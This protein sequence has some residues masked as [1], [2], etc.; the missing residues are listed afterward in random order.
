M[1]HNRFLP[2]AKKVASLLESLMTRLVMRLFSRYRPWSFGAIALSVTSLLLLNF[3]MQPGE[4]RSPEASAL[5]GHRAADAVR[6]SFKAEAK[7]VEK[8]RTERLGSYQLSAGG[9][10][11]AALAPANTVGRWSGVQEWPVVAIHATL[12]PNGKVFA[13][14]TALKQGDTSQ[15]A[16]E[17]LLDGNTRATVWDPASGSFSAADNT[18]GL[19]VNGQPTG[20]NVFCAGNTLLKDGRVFMA[21]GNVNTPS[22]LQGIKLTHLF[23]FQNNNWA[24]GQP[25]NFARWYP[26]VT[27]LYNGEVL[28]TGGQPTAQTDTPEIRANDGVMRTLTSANSANTGDGREYG[29]LRQTLNGKVAY[30]GPKSEMKLLN[31][32][33]NGGKGQ[34]ENLANRDGIDRD[35]GSFAT[36]LPGK[37]L[38]AGGG[39]G[40]GNITNTAVVVDFNNGG[41]TSATQAMTYSRR[42]HNLTLLADGTVL[43]TGGFGG[44]SLESRVDVNNAV[45]IP[46][47]WN[48]ATGTWKTLAPMDRPRMYHST[49]LLLPDGRVLS[50]GTGVCND[51]QTGTSPVNKGAYQR[52]GEVFSPPYLFNSA[53]Q[54]AARPQITAAPTN[55]NYNASYTISSPQAGSIRKLALVRF[56]GVTH[57]INMDQIYVPVNFT[58]TSSNTLRFTSPTTGRLAPHGYYMLFAINDQGVPSVASTLSLKS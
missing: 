25:M 13:Y 35:Y 34:W 56:G 10:N 37:A 3:S 6:T 48:P 22:A 51:C 28:V 4:G 21:G 57:S 50:A 23:S 36:Y 16:T 8:V 54:P 1:S 12:L 17:N 42:Q 52:N 58:V 30:L 18:T 49:A 46:E 38:I 26:T 27:G 5:M 11:R 55:I 41:A 47:L 15:A 32:N 19:V 31:V 45:Y 20:N 7:L 29:W 2:V 24:L 43:A 9:R 33:A 40:G 14:D 53:G 44:G 39:L